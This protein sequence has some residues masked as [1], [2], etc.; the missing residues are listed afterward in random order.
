MKIG[1]RNEPSEGGLGGSESAVVLLAE[2]LHQ[3]RHQ[4]ELVHHRRSL[5]A[6]QLTK[7]TGV[8]LNGVSLRYVA[9]K[10]YSFGTSNNP[11]L[12]YQE[13]QAWQ[14]SLSEPYDLFINSTHTIPAFCHAPRGVLLVLFP[15]KRPSIK[16]L[17]GATGGLPPWNRLKE[18]Y[19][20]WEWKNRLATYQV[21][22]AN[23]RFTQI[24][25]KRRWGVD[26]E[27]VYAP[28]DMDFNIGDKADTILSVGRFATSATSK[29]QFEMVT[30][31]QQLEGC[32]AGWVY[33][34]VGGLGGSSEEHAY[35]ESVREV[36]AECRAQ[37]RANIERANLKLLFE[38]AK[39]FWHAAGYG[40]NEDDRPELTEH[41]GIVTV[42]AMAAGCV[43]IVINKGGQPEI[44]EHG[45]NGFLWNTFEE[46]KKYTMLV[47]RDEQLRRQ[48]AEA[49]RARAQ[50]FSIEEFVNRFITLLQPLLETETEYIS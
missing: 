17:N 27:V 9:P 46:L 29:K 31:F 35:F 10:E 15:Y 45:V 30:A 2:A 32:L 50:F 21:K 43:P 20:D 1:I 36:G 34:C 22:T 48:M 4:V 23:S 28:V 14:A 39:I 6:E 11:W 12:R 18:F 16:P 26:A 42:E 38:R 19:H 40:E 24:W 44:V 8:D 37:V 3:R 47:A 13:A 33:A 25:T 49:A 5:T 41:F 7:F